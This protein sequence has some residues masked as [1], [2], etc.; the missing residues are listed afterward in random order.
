MYE[1]CTEVNDMIINGFRTEQWK[2][3][4]CISD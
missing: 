1:L 3:T 4:I 2:Q